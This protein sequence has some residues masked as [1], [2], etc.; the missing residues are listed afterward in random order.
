M[1]QATSIVAVLA[2]RFHLRLADCMG[3]LEGCKQ[4]QMMRGLVGV[5]G[6][7]FMHFDPQ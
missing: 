7:L 3:G 2:S 4:R 1:A 6:G 5:E